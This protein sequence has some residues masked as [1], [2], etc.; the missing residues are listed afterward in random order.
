[1]IGEQGREETESERRDSHECWRGM[2]RIA[3]DAVP[4]HAMG[5]SEQMAGDLTCT[6]AATERRII[7]C[8]VTGCRGLQL[9][10]L[11]SQER[12]VPGPHGTDKGVGGGG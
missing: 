3:L 7:I 8:L 11:M 4:I 6:W 2:S 1:V 10:T 9:L 5:L 12:T